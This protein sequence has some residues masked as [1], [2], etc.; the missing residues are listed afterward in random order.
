LQVYLELITRS[1]TNTT[2]TTC[3][4]LIVE[5]VVAALQLALHLLLLYPYLCP[6]K[7]TVIASFDKVHIFNR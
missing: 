3:T 2:T 4:T 1:N 5:A 6:L 7:D